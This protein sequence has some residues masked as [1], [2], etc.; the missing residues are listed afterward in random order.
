M[1]PSWCSSGVLAPSFP[2]FHVIFS[3]APLEKEMKKTVVA[4]S[5]RWWLPP[6][7]GARSN[8]AYTARIVIGRE[9]HLE[10]RWHAGALPPE[11]NA[12]CFFPVPLYEQRAVRKRHGEN[13]FMQKWTWEKTGVPVDR[14]RSDV[15]CQVRGQDNQKCFNRFTHIPT[16]E[17]QDE[18]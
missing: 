9:M 3:R 15:A 2:F 8:R 10:S 6:P 11:K 1:F 18:A 16:V 13:F 14:R 5:P 12:G 17:L 4:L 7:H